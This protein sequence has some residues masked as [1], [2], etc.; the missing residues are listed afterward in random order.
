MIKAMQLDDTMAIIKV[1]PGENH[2]A[3]VNMFVVKAEQG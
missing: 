3:P 2:E 1:L